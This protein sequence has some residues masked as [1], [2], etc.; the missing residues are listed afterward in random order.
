[1]F[2]GLAHINNDFLGLRQ[3]CSSQKVLLCMWK[4]HKMNTQMTH[5][6]IKPLVRWTIGPVRPDGFKCLIES[7][8]NFTALYDVEPV[9]CFNCNQALIDQL[10]RPTISAS[11]PRLIDQQNYLTNCV[12]PK[13]VAWKLYPP[14]LALD[15][16]ELIIDNDL[17]IQDKIPELD[18]FFKSDVTLLLEETSRT[19]GRFEKHVPPGLRINSGIYGMPPGF[20]LKKYIDFYVG[21]EW[22][23]NALAEHAANVTFDEQ[24]L[25]AFA[26]SSYPRNVIISSSTI[27]NCEH[28]FNESKGMHFI[29]LNRSMFHQPYRLYK[30]RNVKLHL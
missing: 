19:Y 22:E 6:T 7:I 14:R 21:S 2:T 18:E 10:I 1:M 9:I 5:K 25:V 26:L 13:G 4:D 23:N 28:H 8:S 16:H 27:T 3:F 12:P 15:R 17:I 20:D 29:G 24:G 11:F 30:S